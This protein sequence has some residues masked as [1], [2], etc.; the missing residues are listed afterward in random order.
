RPPRLEA[1]RQGLSE[2]GYVDGRNIAVEIRHAE[3]REQLRIFAAELVHSKVDVLA[4]F[5]DIGLE[6]AQR[7]TTTIPIIALVDDFIGSL[8]RPV[9]NVTGVSLFAQELSAKRLRLLKELRPRI[10]RVR[11]VSDPATC[12]QA[13]SPHDPAPA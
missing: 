3:S 8:A 10:S 5:G 2:S 6:I 7:A 12:T 13:K 9:G 11:A 4:T 1:L